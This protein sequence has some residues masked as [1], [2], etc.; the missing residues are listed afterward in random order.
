MKSTRF[1]SS[2]QEKKVAKTLQGNTTLNSGATSFQK[3]DVIAND[4]VIECKT[5]V[6]PSKSIAIKKEWIDKQRTEALAMRKPNW[7]IAFNFEPNG[8]NFYII[9][10]K[11]FKN[12]LDLLMNLD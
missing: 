11:T 12:M 2:K 9:D 6:E 8:E 3:G 4:F 10:E 7:A 5:K 1:F